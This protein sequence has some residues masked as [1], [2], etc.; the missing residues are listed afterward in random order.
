MKKEKEGFSVVIAVGPG[1]RE[2]VRLESVLE[3]LLAIEADNLIEVVIVDDSRG[4]W[5]YSA[6]RKLHH[7][8]KTVVSPRAG[9]GDGW[10]GGLTT[11]ILFGMKTALQSPQVSFVLKLDTD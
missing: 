11:N 7:S 2:F 9:R 8:I 5:D 6:L 3:G 10:R 1:E 4:R